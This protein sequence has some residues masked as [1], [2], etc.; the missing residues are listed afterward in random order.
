MKQPAAAA[1]KINAELQAR[2]G[3]Q[4]VDVP[5]IR[6][7]SINII[8][9][10][11]LPTDPDPII[12]TQSPVAKVASPSSGQSASKLETDIYQQDGDY[13][14]DIEVNDL[15]NRYTLTRGPTQKMVNILDASAH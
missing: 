10:T 1:A 3:I 14:K 13:I 15:R 9:T 5:P 6:S 12:Q 11:P 4:H 2:R 7:V 8:S